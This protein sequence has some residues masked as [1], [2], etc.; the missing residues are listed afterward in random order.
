MVTDIA[1]GTIMRILIITF[2]LLPLITQAKVEINEQSIFYQVK[3]NEK[4]NLLTAVNS[5]STIREHGEVFHGYTQWNINWRFWWRENKRQCKMTKVKVTLALTLTMP[6]LS[7][8]DQAVHATWN[9]WYPNLMTHEIGHV[10]LAK[11]TVKDIEQSLLT[12]NPSSNCKQLEKAANALAQQKM[13]ELS[14]ASK[15]YDQET[16]HGESQGA[17]L[18]LHL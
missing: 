10:D 11:A 3:V 2:M 14:Q 13:A 6:K 16:N 1:K 17:W 15:R 7:S 5:A 18:Y 4:E 8:N 12:I 9:N